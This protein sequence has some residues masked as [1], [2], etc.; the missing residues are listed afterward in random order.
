MR[1]CAIWPT[2]APIALPLLSSVRLDGT[3]LGWTLLITVST[4]VLFGLVPG[5]RASRAN[6]QE[7][8]KDGGHGTTEGR[9][10]EKMRTVL[11]VSE[12]ALA[13]V[14][15]VGAGLVA[16]EFPARA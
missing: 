3:A 11:V 12:V 5:I 14:L 6:V 13:C 8:L 2:R 9:Q 15:L 16:A 1:S 4:A 10:H 7:A